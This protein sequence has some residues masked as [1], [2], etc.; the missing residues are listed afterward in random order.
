MFPEVCCFESP[1]S[2]D[3]GEDRVSPHLCLELP[4]LA[5][6]GGSAQSPACCPLLQQRFSVTLL[7]QKVASVCSL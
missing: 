5:G 7:L 6:E 1:V 3:W 2:Y 4:W